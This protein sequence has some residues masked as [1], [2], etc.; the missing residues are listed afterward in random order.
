MKTW[1]VD[2]HIGKVERV[3]ITKDVVV[4]VW[5]ELSEIA[6]LAHLN[7]EIV[8]IEDHLVGVKVNVD[9]VYYK[10]W[11]LSELLNY[12]VV[13]IVIKAETVYVYVSA[14]RLLEIGKT[15][16]EILAKLE[17]F[18]G[19]KC[20]EVRVERNSIVWGWRI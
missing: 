3:E 5:N 2:E 17:S 14:I 19:A 4:W 13:K 16:D 8:G 15:K 12:V 11:N 18:F 20:D 1:Y 7:G 10:I 6:K 9:E